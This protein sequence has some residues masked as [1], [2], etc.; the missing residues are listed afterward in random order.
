MNTTNYC[1]AGTCKMQWFLYFLYYVQAAEPVPNTWVQAS[2]MIAYAILM[3]YQL[4]GCSYT[5]P[6]DM[7]P[8]CDDNNYYWCSINPLAGK[9][10][11]GI[12][13]SLA[14]MIMHAIEINWATMTFP[15]LMLYLQIIFIERLIDR[16]A[17]ID[18]VLFTLL[19]E[20]INL[21]FKY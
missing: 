9:W 21:N 7:S 1:I 20:L 10:L 17:P 12:C 8:G 19:L 18:L 6:W 15:L 5:G 4:T 14:L 3:T 2:C 11:F 13:V 16:L